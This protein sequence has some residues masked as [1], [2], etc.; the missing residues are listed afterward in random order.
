MIGVEAGGKGLN[1]HSHAATISKGSVGVLHGMKSLLLQDKDGQVELVHSV[2][3]GLDYPSVGPEHAF[4]KKTGRVD[5]QTVSDKEALSAFHFLSKSEGL[6]PALESAHAIAYA[7]KFARRL[8]GNK[9][10]GIP[11]KRLET[12][13]E[14]VSMIAVVPVGGSLTAYAGKHLAVKI[15]VTG[16]ICHKYPGSFI[17]TE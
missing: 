7:R 1:T 6:I 4:L 8:K 3:A 12:R 15:G 5:Y 13:E 11:G 10:I 9:I 14:F 17:I 16:G 2:S